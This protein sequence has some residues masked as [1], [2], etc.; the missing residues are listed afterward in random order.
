MTSPGPARSPSTPARSPWSPC[1]R[2]EDPHEARRLRVGDIPA[3][4]LTVASCAGYAFITEVGAPVWRATL[5]GF[6]TV[7]AKG[8]DLKIG[9]LEEAPRTGLD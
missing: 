7:M 5:R 4:L 6:L 2:R 8:P 1:S 3:T 9:A